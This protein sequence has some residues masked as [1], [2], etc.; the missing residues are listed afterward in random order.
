MYLSNYYFYFIGVLTL[1]F[2]DDVIKYALSK[3]EVMALT[4]GYGDRKL[5]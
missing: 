2:C 5:Y 3:E 1:K 4:C